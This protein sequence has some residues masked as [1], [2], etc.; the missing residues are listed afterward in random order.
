MPTRFRNVEARTEEGATTQTP[1]IQANAYPYNYVT[2]SLAQ[3][4]VSGMAAGEY[5]SSLMFG[6]Q[7]DLLMKYLETKGVPE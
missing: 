1:V 4:L 2:C 6:V 5:T 7:L 3:S